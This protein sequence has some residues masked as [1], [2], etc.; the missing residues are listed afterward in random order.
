MIRNWFAYERIST[1]EE[2]GLQKFT[3]QDNK[4]KSWGKDNNIKFVYIGKDDASG[5]NFDREDWQR[6]EKLAGAEDGIVFPDLARFTRGDT[7][8]GYRKYMELFYK[9]VT[10]VFIDNPSVN[11]D[12]IK[13]LLNIAESENILTKVLVESIVKILIISEL[14]KCEQERKAIVKR[15]NDGI[16][17]SD[18]KSGR[19]EGSLAKMSSELE[20]DIK[21]YLADRSVKQVDLMKKHNVSRNTLKKYVAIVE[22]NTKAAV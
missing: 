19:K 6:I 20:A 16:A 1:K 18:K 11:T 7:E 14:N 13:E 8:E 21:K 12:N 17:A 3:R 22:Q 5:K 9:G 4:I 15:I 2:R 10:L